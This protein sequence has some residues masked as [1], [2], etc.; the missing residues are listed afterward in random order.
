MSGLDDRL[1]N[2]VSTNSYHG[3]SDL[4]AVNKLAKNLSV[5]VLNLYTGTFKILRWGRWCWSLIFLFDLV[6]KVKL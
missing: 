6:K 2:G 5:L 1:S 4:R 3:K